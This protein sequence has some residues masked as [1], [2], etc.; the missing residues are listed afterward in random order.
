MREVLIFCLFKTNRE[1]AIKR[2][3]DGNKNDK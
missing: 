2:A 3:S 1:S